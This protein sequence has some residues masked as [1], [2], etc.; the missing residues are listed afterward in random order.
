MY[1]TMLSDV[2][3]AHLVS[4]ASARTISHREHTI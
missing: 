4:L 1:L 2:N 3:D